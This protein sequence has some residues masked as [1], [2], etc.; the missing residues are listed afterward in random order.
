MANPADHPGPRSGRGRF[1]SAWGRLWAVALVTLRQGL[2][3]RLWILVIPALIVLIL[4]DLSS[5]RFDPVFEAIPAAV[6]TS[7]L[8]TAVL[9]VVVGVFFSTYSIPDEM[10]SKVSYSV[11]T[12]PV[13]AVEFVAGK[14]L[15]MSLLLAAMLAL[16]A[17]GAYLHIRIRARDLKAQAAR[18][19]AEAKP[20]AAYPADLNALE[21]AAAHGPLRTYRYHAAAEGPLA[22]VRLPP[23]KQAVPDTQWVLGETGMRLSWRLDQT[24]LREWAASGPCVL[25][26]AL[27]TDP[28][29]A[30]EKPVQVVAA[31]VWAD[32][33]LDRE[34][35]LDANTPLHYAKYRVPA[36]GDLEIPVVAPQ[37]TPAKDVLNLPP[38]GELVLDVAALQD[39][40]LVGAKTGALSIVGPAGQMHRVAAAPNISGN[41]YRRRESLAG[42]SRLPRQAAVYRFQ[43]VDPRWLGEADTAV[44]AAFSLDA[45][46][47]GD[48]PALAEMTFIR[49]DGQGK[50]MQFSPEGHHATVVYLDRAFWHG[51]PLEVRLECLTD[52]DYLGLLPESV[53]L[54]LDGG[55]FAL[56]FA[57]A[58][59][60]V[61]LFGTALA[62]VGVLVSTRLTWFVGILAAFGF[63][64]FSIA[65]D[66]IL[67]QTP[68][69]W[70]AKVSARW[71]YKSVA[72]WPGW[73][74]VMQ[75]IL[76]P[77]P[78]LR[79]LLPD[80]RM[81][82]GQ[83]LP[84][85][86]LG[87]ALGWTALGVAAIVLVGAF[88][89]KRR[90]V[91]A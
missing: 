82:L 53:R 87:A 89:L 36:S 83:V 85:A 48:T 60:C 56:H 28:P 57:T 39:G 15:G 44:E 73:L 70:L 22:R 2:R 24:P 8:V 74:P 90:E 88:L 19:L 35:P 14:T 67:T 54:Q 26:L 32:V 13:R 21:A 55:P 52:E 6:S 40:Q 50:T 3:M 12:K 27:A 69:G 20:R 66:F 16:V 75:R 5:P 72:A 11:V 34:G 79:L 51:G 76:A 7:V 63:L 77:V 10:E 43:D 31:T 9:S 91:A 61:W 62:A 33:N 38:E 30:A 78:D 68:V 41:I 59:L 80:D 37:M 64:V 81:S 1:L 71:A 4:S 49:P 46:S 45:W 42:R 84:A 65:H 18:Q 47:R 25:R 23:D 86:D 58:V 29:P 17:S